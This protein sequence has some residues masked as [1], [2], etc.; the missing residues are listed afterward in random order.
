MRSDRKVVRLLLM[1]LGIMSIIGCTESKEYVVHY[2]SLDDRVSIDEV[3]FY[4]SNR[5]PWYHD[6]TVRRRVIEDE[7]SFKVSKDSEY[8]GRKVMY[9]KQEVSPTHLFLPFWNW[10]KDGGDVFLLVY[11]YPRVLTYDEKSGIVT[12]ERAT[13]AEGYVLQLVE[14]GQAKEVFS[15]DPEI[16]LKEVRNMEEEELD[17]LPFKDLYSL[18]SESDVAVVR[19]GVIGKLMKHSL[20]YRNKTMLLKYLI[21]WGPRWITFGSVYDK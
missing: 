14:G 21:Q 5:F 9:G 20:R 19:K 1:F 13:N 16:S 7:F 12:V 10:P 4:F 18:L 6:Y 11:P 17:A 2:I 15:L 8:L 3:E